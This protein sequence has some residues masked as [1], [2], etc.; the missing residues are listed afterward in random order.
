MGESDLQER[1]L[2]PFF[3]PAPSNSYSSILF[4]PLKL[5][6]DIP[7]KS[8][9][10]RGQ[11]P[12]QRYRSMSAP[13]SNGPNRHSA[14]TWDPCSPAA[15]S[16]HRATG[17]ERLRRLE[18]MRV[19]GIG[20][21]WHLESPLLLSPQ[22][23]SALPG[24][25]I[26]DDRKV[27]RNS[28][29]PPIMPLRLFQGISPSPGVEGHKRPGLHPSSKYLLEWP[30]ACLD[31]ARLEIA[32]RRACGVASPGFSPR[33]SPDHSRIPTWRVRYM[34]GAWVPGIPSDGRSA[35]LEHTPH[36]PHSHR[37]QSQ[38]GPPCALRLACCIRTLLRPEPAHEEPVRAAATRSGP[39]SRSRLS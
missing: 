8:P 13:V 16:P 30:S 18:I 37:F 28:R 24:S 20:L 2:F 10:V 6:S 34:G 21:T 17:C 9:C 11:V 38:R 3:L 36:C 27:R 1:A 12:P 29:E 19:S 35:R 22:P 4:T 15:G 26:N 39:N 32:P 23:R 25:R 31:R 33:G 7:P 14:T 5:Y